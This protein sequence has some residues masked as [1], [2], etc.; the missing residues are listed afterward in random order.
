MLQY[1]ASSSLEGLR[2][3]AVVQ[4][5]QP[6]FA[7]VAEDACRSRSAA[8]AALHACKASAASTHR[9]GWKVD[10]MAKVQTALTPSR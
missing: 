4:R 1:P 7:A 10:L 6:G 8:T 3:P 9:A 5:L 2:W